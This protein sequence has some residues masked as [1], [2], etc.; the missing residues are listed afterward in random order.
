M[1]THMPKFVNWIM[2]HNEDGQNW[3]CNPND[4]NLRYPHLRE[5]DKVF[6]QLMNKDFILGCVLCRLKE[7]FRDYWSDASTTPQ[8]HP[9]S[10]PD[11]RASIA[12]IHGLGEKWSCERVWWRADEGQ[13]KADVMKLNETDDELVIRLHEETSQARDQRYAEAVGQHCADEYIDTLLEQ[14]LQSIHPE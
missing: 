11:D 13:M 5:N 2:E 6:T 10:F 7:F 1:L 8:N 12:P 3:P 9:T 14:V 4:P